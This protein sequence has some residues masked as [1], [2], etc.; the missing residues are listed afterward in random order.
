MGV[1]TLQEDLTHEA[2]EN[3]GLKLIESQVSQLVE[4]QA[5]RS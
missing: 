3:N 2:M 1:C 5:G 4:M